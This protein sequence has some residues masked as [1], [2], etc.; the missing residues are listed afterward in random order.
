MNYQECDNCKGNGTTDISDANIA[1]YGLP[2]RYSDLIICQT[3]K[4]KIVKNMWL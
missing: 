2:I 3:Y 4:G 1:P